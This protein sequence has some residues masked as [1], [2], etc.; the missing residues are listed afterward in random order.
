ML[1]RGGQGVDDMMRGGGG[2]EGAGQG[3]RE[4]DNT[5]RGGGG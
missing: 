3:E 1:P 5:T 2:V 4:G